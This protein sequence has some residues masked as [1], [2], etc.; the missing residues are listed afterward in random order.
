MKKFVLKKF[1][2]DK[3]GNFAVIFA[4]TLVP[5]IAAASAVVE[6]TNIVRTKN[7][8][9]QT[10]DSA[11]IHI[12]LEAANGYSET[13]LE[14][15]GTTFFNGNISSVLGARTTL[16]YLGVTT[17]PDKSLRYTANLTKVYRG[18]LSN[19]MDG[20]IKVGSVVERVAG[21]PACL[22]ALSDTASSAVDFNGTTNVSLTNCIITANSK[23]ATAI[24]RSGS[25][26]VNAECVQT[27]GRTSGMTGSRVTLACP[28]MKEN[29]FKT[30][31]PLASIV[32]PTGAGCST[33]TIPGGNGWKT[34]NPGTYC[35]NNVTVNGGKQIRFNSGNYIFKG[36]SIN[37]LGG[38]EIVGTGVTIFLYSGAKLDVAANSNVTLSAPTTGTSG[39]ILVYTAASNPVDLR[40]SG[41]ATQKLQ[42]F[43]YNPKG[44]VS[45]KGNAGTSADKCVRLI[46][47]TITMTGT[48]ALKMDCT[49]EL[50]GR[51][52]TTTKLVRIVK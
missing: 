38:A 15:K 32:P 28:K 48:S 37:F 3:K 46:G 13:D 27:V 41:G 35:N 44:N 52:I 6:T 33:L 40:F 5:L 22:L 31:D 49:A 4:I 17:T 24:T 9:Q 42:G 2:Q 19:L 29:S 21:E 12:A 30:R 45:F 36:T 34:I 39:G 26:N 47:D 20:P 18:D 43:I 11:L 23:S 25:A 1:L 16:D 7:A 51:D 10:L 50:A 14:T 8:V